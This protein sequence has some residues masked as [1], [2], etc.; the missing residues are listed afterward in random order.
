M[1]TPATNRSSHLAS[2][3]RNDCWNKIGMRGDASC[4]ELKI[5]IHCRNCPVY[6]AAAIEILDRELPANY[7]EQW[8][9][10]IAKEQPA[11]QGDMQSVVVFRIASEWFALPTSVFKEIVGIRPV[12]SLPHRRNGMVLGVTNIRGELL[13]CISLRQ[14]LRL[15]EAA[16][17]KKEG[18]RAANARM[19]FLQHEDLRAVCP[20]DEVFGVHRFH[21]RELMAVPTILSKATPAFTKAVLPWGQ[22]T[23]GLLDETLLFYSVNRGLA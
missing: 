20:V 11:A 19:L 18:S 15:D 21:L 9:R 5:H 16:E 12:H 14:I 23:V 7:L 3:A 4:P 1:S 22:G 17:S 6:S 10:Y 2:L 8:T 13:V